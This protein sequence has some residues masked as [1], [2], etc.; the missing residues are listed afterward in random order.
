MTCRHTHVSIAQ[1]DNALVF[2][3]KDCGFE[4]RWRFN[5]ICYVNH[6]IHVSA[7]HHTSPRNIH[8]HPQVRQYRTNNC[9][10]PGGKNSPSV[11]PHPEISK[12]SIGIEYD[13]RFHKHESPVNCN[14]YQDRYGGRVFP[15]HHSVHLTLHSVV[16]KIY[17]H[18]HKHSCIRSIGYSPSVDIVCVGFHQSNSSWELPEVPWLTAHDPTSVIPLAW[19]GRP[20]YLRNRP[21]YG[22]D[23][24]EEM[25]T[26]FD[27]AGRIPIY[28]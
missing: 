19:T 22:I 23:F 6:N 8:Q 18:R 1:L 25:H 11:V 26:P 24:S 5:S 7:S 4:S 13:G 15:Q 10:Q 21:L 3:T 27:T 9:N 2:G 16:K 17:I 12:W 20:V 14:E 28:R